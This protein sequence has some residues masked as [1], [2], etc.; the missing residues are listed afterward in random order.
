[1]ADLT[2]L[3]AAGTTKIVGSSTLGLETNAVGATA[4]GDLTVSDGL[5]S[6]GV[7][8]SVTLTTLG[9]AYEARVGIS[10]LS[11]RKLLTITAMND[12]FWGYS[13]SVTINNG[14]PL[15]KN[16]QL[17]FDIDPNSDFQVWVVSATNGASIRIT[18]S[19]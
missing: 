16:Q 8:G 3:Q 18:E 5:K 1:M 10:R 12:I 11:N 6:G 17:I 19:P 7:F 4:N 2:D 14:T 15:F 13:N 9:T